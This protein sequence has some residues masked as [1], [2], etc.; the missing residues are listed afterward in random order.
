M[1]TFTDITNWK[2]TIFKV[3]KPLVDPFKQPKLYF[4]KETALNIDYVGTHLFLKCL[5]ENFTVP[6][7]LPNCSLWNT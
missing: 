5:K 3:F 6:L 7:N 2:M 1:E 4:K